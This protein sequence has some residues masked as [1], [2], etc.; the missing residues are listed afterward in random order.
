MPDTPVALATTRRSA[1]YGWRG[2]LGMLVP[3]VNTCAEPDAT[4]SMPEGVTVHSARLRLRGSTREEYLAMTEDVEQAASLLA[5]GEPDLIVF[6]CTAVSTLDPAMGESICR[7]IETATGRPATAT[8]DALLAGFRTLGAKRVVLL[9]PYIAPVN[10][11][12]VAWLAHYGIEAVAERGLGIAN[13]AEMPE[14]T[15]EQW[16][17]EARALRH[18]GADAYFISCTNIRVR[19]AVDAMEAE[20]G[21]PVVTSNGAMI[22]HC[23]RQMG[24]ADQRPGFGTLL[25]RH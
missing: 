2:R 6:H 16:R 4:A 5:D 10:R 12:E 19:A 3:S 14:V 18:D 13:G 24:I 17:A 22:W 11:S 15:P 23:L 20:L 8:S 1:G 7:R 9:S 25:A 21:R